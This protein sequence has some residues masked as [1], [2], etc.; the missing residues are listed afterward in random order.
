MWE[1]P[2]LFLCC[3]SDFDVIL[4]DI[5]MPILNGFDASRCIRANGYEQAIIGVSA[6]RFI[7]RT[8]CTDAGMSS[9]I[10]KPFLAQEIGET[11]AAETL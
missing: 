2:V 1:Y 5:N 7:S 4:I 11:L 10:L 3:R 9:L 6:D 8:D